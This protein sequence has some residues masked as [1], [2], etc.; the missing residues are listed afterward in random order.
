[1][2]SPQLRFLARVAQ[3]QLFLGRELD[4]LNLTLELEFGEQASSVS[5]RFLTTS[6]RSVSIADAPAG[7]EAGGRRGHPLPEFRQRTAR[8]PLELLLAF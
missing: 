8:V 3:Q 7:A 1:M 2:R 4:L 6:P 5:F